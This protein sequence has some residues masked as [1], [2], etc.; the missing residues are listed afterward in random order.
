MNESQARKLRAGDRVTWDGNPFDGGSVVS[1]F[2]H[3]VEVRWDNSPEIGGS[4]HFQDCGR[5]DR[6]LNPSSLAKDIV[7]AYHL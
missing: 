2:A 5:M 7:V 6:G 1:V 3:G 4:L